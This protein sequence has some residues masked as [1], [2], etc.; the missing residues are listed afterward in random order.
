MTQVE[1]IKLTKM[2]FV[3][4]SEFLLLSLIKSSH[5]VALSILQLAEFIKKKK[6][7][8]VSHTQFFLENTKVRFWHLF[9]F[10]FIGKV[11]IKTPKL[12]VL[13]PM[14]PWK[15]FCG[16]RCENKAVYKPPVAQ[17]CMRL[18]RSVKTVMRFQSGRGCVRV[19]VPKCRQTSLC[20]ILDTMFMCLCF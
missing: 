12:S 13:S 18:V 20:L 8:A 3:G 1:A 19:S 7:N 4:L 5:F 10:L 17:W 14:S 11:K 15:R 6:K 2:C 16:S 9:N